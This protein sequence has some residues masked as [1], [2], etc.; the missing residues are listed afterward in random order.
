MWKMKEGGATLQ[1]ILFKIMK[2]SDGLSTSCGSRYQLIMSCY[3]CFGSLFISNHTHDSFFI[4][5][6]LMLL[7]CLRTWMYGLIIGPSLLSIGLVW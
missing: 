1:D 3:I 5:P 2:E 7:V 6:T 4:H